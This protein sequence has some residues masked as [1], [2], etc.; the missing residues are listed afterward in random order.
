M[1]LKCWS[2]RPEE[3][4]EFQDLFDWFSVNP[5]YMNLTELLRTQDLGE[6]CKPQNKN[7]SY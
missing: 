5:E 4:P 2:Y 6:L 3:R 7:L 1:M